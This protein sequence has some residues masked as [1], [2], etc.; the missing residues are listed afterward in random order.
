MAGGKGTRFWPKSTDE[1]PKQFAN[2]VSD[3]SMLEETYER[4]AKFVS[5]E[6]I[7][8]ST[9]EQYRKIIEGYTFLNKSQIIYEPE[10]RDT[11][12]AIA[13]CVLA[14]GTDENEILFF[15][16]A[17]HFIL[18]PNEF[19]KNVKEAASV[20][21]QK[22]SI[23]LIG[24]PPTSP[25]SNYGY[26]EIDNKNNSDHKALDVLSFKEKPTTE[27]AYEYLQKGNYLWNGG[28]FLFSRK[29]IL[30]EFHKNG[31]DILE[32]TKQYLSQKEND[33]ST[34]NET[35]HTIRKISFDY[36]IME[37]AKSIACIV[38]SFGWDDV[39]SWNALP[40]IKSCDS[41]LNY[42][43]ANA[44]LYKCHNTTIISEDKNRLWVLN[45][46]NDLNIIE[47]NNIVYITRKDAEN[48]IKNI[49]PVLKEHKNI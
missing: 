22:Q 25:S 3:K 47:E 40:R 24:I 8:V 32:L 48:E 29:I 6:N 17:D 36:A 26:L 21:S 33:I 16:P 18:N 14:S 12:A 38:A 42:S 46:L 23:V 28:M 43:Q 13:L 27:T 2:I 15:A 44:F 1:K 9:G 20:A 11:A 19:E 4:F 49:L 45:N 7:F 30:E 34:A 41:E 31:A 5:P 37:K 10:G 39:G 35:F